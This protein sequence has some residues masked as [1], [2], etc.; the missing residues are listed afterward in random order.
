LPEC[1]PQRIAAK[2]GVLETRGLPL[3]LRSRKVVENMIAWFASMAVDA[4]VGLTEGDAS[5]LKVR[6][7]VFRA[8]AITDKLTLRCGG[9]SWMLHLNF[10]VADREV[11]SKFRPPSYA[12]VLKSKTPPLHPNCVNQ[13]LMAECSKG[14]DLV[15]KV[16]N[17]GDVETRS[18]ALVGVAEVS[19]VQHFPSLQPHGDCQEAVAECSRKRELVDEVGSL[20]IMEKSSVVQDTIDDVPLIQEVVAVMEAN[21]KEMSL[22]KEVVSEGL[23]THLGEP[24]EG[25]TINVFNEHAVSDMVDLSVNHVN[26]Q[27]CSPM[28]EVVHSKSKTPS[29]ARSWKPPYK[30]RL[31]RHTPTPKV[32]ESVVAAVMKVSRTSAAVEGT[33]LI[34]K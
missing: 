3:H 33:D 2:F 25:M 24:D 26:L 31:R 1:P 21:G 17:L 16:G 11:V 6:V 29:I 32:D 20:R 5:A 15:D 18:E 8:S 27:S 7:K 28:A 10:I 4:A 22:S 13:E 14:R 19:L 23:K 12:M 30:L 9:S 34:P